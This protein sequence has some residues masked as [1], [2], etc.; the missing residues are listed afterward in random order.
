MN[1]FEKFKQRILNSTGHFEN[2]TIYGE[3]DQCSR[4]EL[5]Y[6]Q[7]I[8]LQDMLNNFEIKE[9]NN[10]EYKQPETKV[11]ELPKCDFCNNKASYDM[12]MAKGGYWAYV[13]EEHKKLGIKLGVGY[14][15]RLVL[16]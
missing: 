15:Q 8:E 3:M 4:E 11:D 12:K 16:E 2:S 6:E 13:C 7:T 10:N 9:V 1:K 14:G 5:T